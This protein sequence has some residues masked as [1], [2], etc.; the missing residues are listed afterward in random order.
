MPYLDPSE[1]IPRRELIILAQSLGVDAGSTAAVMGISYH[2]LK[3]FMR[4][5]AWDRLGKWSH[6]IPKRQGATVRT[7]IGKPYGRFKDAV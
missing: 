3:S 2:T 6:R 5:H 4:K 1:I 7:L